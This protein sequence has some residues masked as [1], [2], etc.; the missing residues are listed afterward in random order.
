MSIDIKCLQTP[1]WV[2]V[3]HLFYIYIEALK[4]HS[5]NRVFIFNRPFNSYKPR[6]STASS[7]I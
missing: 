2:P 7:L 5:I 1:N 6:L 3:I 4:P